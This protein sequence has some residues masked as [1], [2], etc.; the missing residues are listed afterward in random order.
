MGPGPRSGA[1]GTIQSVYIH[2]PDLNSI[3]ISTY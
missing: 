3:E 2:D 1:V